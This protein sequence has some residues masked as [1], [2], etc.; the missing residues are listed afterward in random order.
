[1]FHLCQWPKFRFDSIPTQP[2]SFQMQQQTFH[3]LMSRGIAKN[4][5]AILKDPLFKKYP[6][7]LCLS[8]ARSSDDTS[9]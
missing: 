2:L 1:M 9:I 3:G 5:E 6:T 4:S 7:L 8:K